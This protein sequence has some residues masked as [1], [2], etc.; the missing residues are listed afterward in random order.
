MLHDQ[1]TVKQIYFQL[2]HKLSVVDM[3]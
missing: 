3:R 1:L 2:P